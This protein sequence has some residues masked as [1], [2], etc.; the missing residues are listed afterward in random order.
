MEREVR[1]SETQ[2]WPNTLHENY[3][4]EKRAEKNSSKK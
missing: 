1:K 2:S 4:T 3:R